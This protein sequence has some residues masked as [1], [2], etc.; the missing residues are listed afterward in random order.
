[1]YKPE[2]K[3]SYYIHYLSYHCCFL[4]ASP[5]FG[6]GDPLANFSWPVEVEMKGHMVTVESDVCLLERC[7]HFGGWYVQASMELGPEDVSLLE[8][9]PHFRGKY[10]VYYVPKSGRQSGH[11]S[12]MSYFFSRVSWL[13][14][15]HCQ[16][17]QNAMNMLNAHGYKP[18]LHYQ[19]VLCTY[20]QTTI[21]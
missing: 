13:E 1:M 20:K 18:T 6:T 10:R 2:F 17:L 19:R 3:L 21:L 16:T 7:P 11:P 8:R 14:R 15:F 12:L 4:T 9:C 5:P